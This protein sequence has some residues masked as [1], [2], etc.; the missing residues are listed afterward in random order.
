MCAACGHT[1]QAIHIFQRYVHIFWIPV[2][3]I[4]QVRVLECKGCEK[5]TPKKEFGPELKQSMDRVGIS[6]RP[7]VWMLSGILI[8][9]LVVGGFR[10]ERIPRQKRR[11]LFRSRAADYSHGEV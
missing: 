8:F 10:K 9:A 4:N 11:R 2:F 5:V 7:P 1:E 3:P 6:A